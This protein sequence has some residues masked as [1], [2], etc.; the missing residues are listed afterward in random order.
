MLKRIILFLGS[1]LLSYV[2]TSQPAVIAHD[3]LNILYRNYDNP[4][5]ISKNGYDCSE[6]SLMIEDNAADSAVISGIGCHYTVRSKGTGG[7]WLIVKAEKAG[8]LPVYDTIYFRTQ[9][10]PPPQLTV[11]GKLLGG[12]IGGTALSLQSG[13][14]PTIHTDLPL[15]VQVLSYDMYYHSH[16]HVCPVILRAE[17]P[18]FTSEMIKVL[19]NAE[20]EDTVII[21]N[22]V[23][24][25]NGQTMNGDFSLT[26]IITDM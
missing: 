7:V 26:F 13:L 8:S 9:S 4:I 22:A 17:G 14:V 20:A 2:V 24:R 11:G 25:Y 12:S 19:Q 21:R 6:L 15:R 3:Q 1:I 16:R 23:L 10:I 5:T 18:L